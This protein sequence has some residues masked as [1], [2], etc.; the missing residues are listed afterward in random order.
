MT[1]PQIPALG[2]HPG[3]RS[4]KIFGAGAFGLGL[5][6]TACGILLVLWGLVQGPNWLFLVGIGLIAV[7]LLTSLLGMVLLYR[8]LT[9][10]PRRHQSPRPEEEE[11]P[12]ESGN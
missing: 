4:R 12:S 3:S 11:N 1:D 7:G 2:A 6:I 9:G 5:L 8:A 10:A